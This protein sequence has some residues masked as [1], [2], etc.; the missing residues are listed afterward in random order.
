MIH[1]IVINLFLLHF[2]LQYLTSSQFFSHFFRQEK[3]RLQVAQIF[4]G[5][6]GFLC[7]IKNG[8]ALNQISGLCKATHLFK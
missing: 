2:S 6:W 5:S 3:D 4:T 8:F 7:G 1:G